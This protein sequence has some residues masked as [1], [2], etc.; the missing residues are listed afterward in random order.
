[1]QEHQGTSKETEESKQE[2]RVRDLLSRREITGIA[3][4][5]WFFLGGFFLLRLYVYDH[6]PADP[7]RTT[8]LIESMFSL[9]IV[10]VIVVHAIMYYKQAQ[11]AN[12]QASASTQ[13]IEL[14][15]RNECAYIRVGDLKLPQPI[16]NNR[17]VIEGK[18]YNGGRTPA[19]NFQRQIQIAIGTP[20]PP[21]SDWG[22]NWGDSDEESPVSML[23]AGG[24]VDF[25]AAIENVT[26]DTLD[27]V[28]R[29]ELVILLDGECRYI[30]SLGGKV[31]YRFG[32]TFE[33]EPPK[34]VERY[35]THRREKAN[36][37]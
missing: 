34:A 1:M 30:D 23:V 35:Q 4:A 16:R 17:L 12:K 8:V 7:G 3:I 11:E 25:G 18:F 2:D 21:P 22:V 36:P 13:M 24:D 9:A 10:I 37:N 14:I 15:V 19:W 29:D 20:V 27:R 5:I 32:Y 6:I 26:Q 28:N 33:L 31:F